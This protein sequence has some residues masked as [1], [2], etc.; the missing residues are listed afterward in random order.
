MENYYSTPLITTGVVTDDLTGEIV[1]L[2]GC[3]Y[4]TTDPEGDVHDGDENSQT[5]IAMQHT[6]IDSYQWGTLLRRI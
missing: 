4:G 3:E 6:S 5:S 1:V 2:P